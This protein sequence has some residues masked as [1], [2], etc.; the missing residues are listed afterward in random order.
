MED[1]QG[2]RKHANLAFGRDAP[3]PHIDSATDQFKDALQNVKSRGKNREA[4]QRRH[5]LAWAA[6]DHRP[7][8]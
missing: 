5:A 1:A 2:R 6:R 7:A 3:D 4:D 8:T